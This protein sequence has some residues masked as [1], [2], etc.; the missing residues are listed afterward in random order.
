MTA[1]ISV[2]RATLADIPAMHRIRLAVRENVLSRPDLL[3]QDAYPV[4]LTRDGRGWVSE[5]DGE[6]A[7]FSVARRNG[8]I[9]ALFVDPPR[10]GRGHG[11]AL[12][13]AMIAW[14]RA[15]GIRRAWLSTD[16]ATRADAFYRAQGWIA[17]EILD[18]GELA[19]ELPL[20]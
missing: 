1:V 16:P 11:R 8:N 18:D 19:F 14:M 17:G 10:E 2:R 3:T 15:E 20:D 12:H 13:D 5:E 7:G 6:I 4:E 9:W